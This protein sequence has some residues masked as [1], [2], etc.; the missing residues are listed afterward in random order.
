MT[1]LFDAW[2]FVA[3]IGLFI[4][5]MMLIE[6][7]VKNLAGRSFKIFLKKQTG[8]PLRA[9]AGGHYAQLPG[10]PLLPHCYKVALW[11]HSWCLPLLVLALLP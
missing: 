3:G 7:A 4:Y 2:K 8:N 6:D 1:H 11:Y 9:I 5:A 10:E